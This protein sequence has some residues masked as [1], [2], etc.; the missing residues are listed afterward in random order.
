MAPQAS[1]YP[2]DTAGL[3]SGD[4]AQDQRTAAACLQ[5]LTALFVVE[6]VP[7]WSASL[8]SRARLQ[9]TPKRH[10][11]D[12]SLATA[13]LRAVPERLLGDLKTRG[14]L[15]ESLAVRDLRVYAQA[16]EAT[17]RHFRD[18]HGNEIDAVVD[19]GDG[20]W[21]AAEVKLGSMDAVD[22][23]ECSIPAGVTDGLQGCGGCWESPV[24]PRG[25]RDGVRSHADGGGVSLLCGRH[26]RAQ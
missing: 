21:L 3:S 5:A 7:A 8:R 13:A 24:T 6:D 22:S 19:W 18:S 9:G 20:R 10:F 1:S 17:V 15:F 23:D 4:N 14:F 12:P 2:A 26:A 25:C 11:V 16:R